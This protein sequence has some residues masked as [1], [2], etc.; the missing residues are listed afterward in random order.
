M[1][2]LTCTRQRMTRATTRSARPHRKEYQERAG[3]TVRPRRAAAEG[4]D[5]AA[6]LPGERRLTLEQ[7]KE[8]IR[9]PDHLLSRLPRLLWHRSAQHG[10]A[11]VRRTPS[12]TCPP[13]RHRRRCGFLPGSE[14]EER[15]R[16]SKWPDEG[17][18]LRSGLQD[19]RAPLHGKLPLLHPACTPARVESSSQVLQ[20]DQGQKNCIGKIFRCTQQGEPST[21]R[22]LATSTRSSA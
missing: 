19:R 4:S 22:A 12:W 15:D 3:S 10:R 8:G 2:A 13:A 18:L 1:E 9:L 20:L 11:S 7:I 16:G 21:W 6:G 5:G 14:T 17:T